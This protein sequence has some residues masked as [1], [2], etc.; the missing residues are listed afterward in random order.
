M[1]PE[2][3]K[4][5]SRKTQ[6]PQKRSTVTLAGDEIVEQLEHELELS[7]REAN[8][9]FAMMFAELKESIMQERHARL[10]NVGSFILEDRDGGKAVKFK[11]GKDF[12]ARI[13]SYHMS[14]L[15]EEACP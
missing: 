5:K 13:I 2:N 15:R 6:A 10:A 14:K 8:E 1:A 4:L 3:S 12:A 11:P 7:S 9:M